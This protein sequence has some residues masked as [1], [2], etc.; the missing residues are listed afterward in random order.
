MGMH[1][2]P[3]GGIVFQGATTDWPILV[4][5]NAHVATITRNVIERLRLPSVRI[6]GPLPHRAGRMLAA[7]G[8]TV[9]FH[10][11]AGAFGSGDELR[12]EWQVAGAEHRAGR[13]RAAAGADAERRRIS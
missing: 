2:T 12:W 3:R 8:E 1:V 7:A 10:A 9:T 5:R 6:I 4:P 13:G 11:D